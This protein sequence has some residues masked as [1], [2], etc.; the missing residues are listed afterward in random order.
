MSDQ[1]SSTLL[2]IIELLEET[3]NPWLRAKLQGLAVEFAEQV[4]SYNK[5]VG[6]LLQLVGMKHSMCDSNLCV[7]WL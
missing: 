7:V 6:A 2:E 5:S 3:L 1:D 4:S